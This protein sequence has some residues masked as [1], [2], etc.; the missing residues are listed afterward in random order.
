MRTRR[1]RLAIVLVS[2]AVL[3]ATLVV[4][5]DDV[6]TRAAL[7][8]TTAALGQTVRQQRAVVGQLDSVESAVAAAERRHQAAGAALEQVSAE[9]AQ[10]RGA[11]TN[12]D[13]GVLFSSV[14]IEQ[15]NTCLGGVVEALNQLAVGQVPGAVSSLNAVHQDCSTV[16]GAA[17]G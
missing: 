11:L 13:Q 6:G 9:L 5:R 14:A 10:T 3:A 15:L 16:A 12:T 2:A 17:G 8:R 7:A 4:W 1:F